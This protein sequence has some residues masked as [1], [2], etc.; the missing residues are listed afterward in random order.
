MTQSSRSNFLKTSA[1]GAAT[2][3]ATNVFAQYTTLFQNTI[4]EVVPLDPKWIALYLKY[5][6]D[7]G[8]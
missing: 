1:V 5:G 3:S 4:T 8:I 2:F 7:R 6:N